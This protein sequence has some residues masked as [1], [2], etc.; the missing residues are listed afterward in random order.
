MACHE[1]LVLYVY[2]FLRFSGTSRF[3][4]LRDVGTLRILLYIK[5]FSYFSINM[6]AVTEK[7]QKGIRGSDTSVDFLRNHDV[8]S[9]AETAVL[10]TPAEQALYSIF[11]RPNAVWFV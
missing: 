10:R 1:R 5:R 9:I 4:E 2:C 11:S 8:L 7:E 3:T 6:T